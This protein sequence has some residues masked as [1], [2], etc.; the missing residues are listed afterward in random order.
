MFFMYTRY[1][2]LTSKHP[3]GVLPEED[4]RLMMIQNKRDD[5]V[6]KKMIDENV[7]F[8]PKRR[9]SFENVKPK[10]EDMSKTLPEQL[11]FFLVIKDD[12]NSPEKKC[13]TLNHGIWKTY[14]NMNEA[15]RD[16]FHVPENVSYID[17]RVIHYPENKL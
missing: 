1:L 12:Q 16:F 7:G 2:D 8:F 4:F 15:V 11:V 9:K 17:T 13:I 3:I 5:L 10:M 6:K 14:N